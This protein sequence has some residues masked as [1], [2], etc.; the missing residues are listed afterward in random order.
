MEAEADTR[1]DADVELLDDAEVDLLEEVAPMPAAE[2]PGGGEADVDDDELARLADEVDL[3]DLDAVAVESTDD[4]L[5][6]SPG[7]DLAGDEDDG[8]DDRG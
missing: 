8:T 5:F 6:D 4:S 2:A 1:P 7:T 3:S